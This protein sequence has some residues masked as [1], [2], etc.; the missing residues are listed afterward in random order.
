[1]SFVLRL[2]VS[3]TD[4]ADDRA[5]VEDGAGDPDPAR[6]DA[7]ARGRVMGV[8][9]IAGGQLGTP[10]RGQRRAEV[11]QYVAV[12][13]RASLAESARRPPDPRIF[14]GVQAE[15]VG[16]RREPLVVP[17]ALP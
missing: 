16:Q 4:G 13:L 7:H 17:A 3:A 1:M 6:A 2:E 11:G 15:F 8:V 9:A 14:G 12:N 5:E 10:V